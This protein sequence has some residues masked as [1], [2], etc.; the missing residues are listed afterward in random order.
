MAR[1]RGAGAVFALSTQTAGFFERLGYR[2]Q[3]GLSIVPDERRE[4]WE[5][6]GRNALLLVKDLGD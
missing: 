4:R 3:S 2:R 1:Q 5:K 6:S